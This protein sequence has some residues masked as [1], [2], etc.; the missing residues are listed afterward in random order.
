MPAVIRIVWRML[1][2]K[3]DELYGTC[4]LI[5][6]NTPTFLTQDGLFVPKNLQYFI[7]NELAKRGMTEAL[8][9]ESAVFKATPT[10]AHLN[11]KT[12][13][14]TLS[15]SIFYRLNFQLSN[16][17]IPSIARCCC[18]PVICAN[19]VIGIN[20]KCTPLDATKETSKNPKIQK[21]EAPKILR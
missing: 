7:Y 5:Y 14:S 9:Q 4:H 13:P 19:H 6:T 10:G 12:T 18:H 1:L 8:I 16:H 11:T 20:M 15:P 2:P 17:S 3:N 21:S